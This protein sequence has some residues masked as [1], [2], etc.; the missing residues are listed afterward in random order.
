[1]A[2]QDKIPEVR[3]CGAVEVLHHAIEADPSMYA[4][5]AEIEN[6]VQSR[7]MPWE[8]LRANPIITIPVVVHVVYHK[9][10]ENISDAQ[11]MS[12]IDALNADFAASND[13]QDKIPAVWRG[14]SNDSRIRFELARRDPNG[15]PTNG[16][17]RTETDR[18]SFGTRHTVKSRATGGADQWPPDKYLNIWVCN[19][20]GLLGY[21]TFPGMPREIDGVVV[22][23]RAFGS[24]GYLSD[25]FNRGRTA[26]H[27]VG[28]WLNLI[29]IWGD[30]KD[31]SGTD[32]VSDT[33]KAHLP[34]Y[35]TPQFPHIS[36]NN[37]PN[38]DMF[39]NYMDYVDD[40]AM[41]MFTSGQIAR[42]QA[43]L[44]GPRSDIVENAH[45][46]L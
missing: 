33:P 29:H 40:A 6:S 5:L 28:H 20:N 13:D 24:T 36:C 10:E 21:A 32:Y 26:V 43:T 42:M 46:V 38:G 1:M 22:L 9:A 23:N 17:T 2:D 11:I 35:D 7:M 14:L 27:E 41:F 45:T 30:T 19:L 31:C 12:Q 8:T 37:A 15:T 16:I 39:M 3:N 4:R 18:T 25:K 34:N 44:A